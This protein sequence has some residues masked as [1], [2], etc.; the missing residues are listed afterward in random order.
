M[1]DAYNNRVQIFD[2]YNNRIQVF[3]QAG[4]LLGLFGNADAESQQLKR[5]TDVAVAEDGSIYVVDFGHDRITVF[6]Q[7]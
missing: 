4:T 3:S 5:P 2:F 7:D 6:R 1:A